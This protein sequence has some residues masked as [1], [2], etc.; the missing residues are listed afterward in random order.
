[1][2]TDFRTRVGLAFT[3]IPSGVGAEARNKAEAAA[4]AFITSALSRAP[5][6][7]RLGEVGL[8]V[9][10]LVWML[11]VGWKV[12]GPGGAPSV[13]LRVFAA[14][15]GPGAKLIRLYSSL[16]SFAY[17]EHDEV[18]LALGME[19]FARRQDIFRKAMD[20]ASVERDG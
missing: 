5:W 3:P 15:P 20:T 17:Y 9:I 16:A 12:D 11:P 18:R 14:L 1:M 13:W 19:P 4:Q 10:L 7:V 2:S 6:F 8:R